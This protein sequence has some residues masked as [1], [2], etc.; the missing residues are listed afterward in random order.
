M[1]KGLGPRKRRKG[2]GRG[3][4]NVLKRESNELKGADADEEWKA[5]QR[6][7]L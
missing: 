2:E 5:S 3:A 7:A 6:W 1:R 4:E